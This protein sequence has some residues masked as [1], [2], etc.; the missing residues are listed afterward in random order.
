MKKLLTILFFVSI[1]NTLY[2]QTIFTNTIYMWGNGTGLKE[3]ASPATPTL[4]YGKLFA[5][6]DGH[7][8]WI[9]DAA[10]EFDLTSGSGG[11]TITTFGNGLSFSLGTLSLVTQ[12][13][14]TTDASGLKLVGDV[15]S[16]GNNKF[17][18]TNSVGTRTWAGIKKADLDDL[19]PNEILFGDPASSGQV[20]QND[21]ITVDDAND[22]LGVGVAVPLAT[23]HS[24]ASANNTGTAFPFYIETS[25]GNNVLT[26]ND[27]GV[28]QFSSENF[29]QG[30][31]LKLYG[32]ALGGS[33]FEGFIIHEGTNT[34]FRFG[35]LNDAT[36]VL[37]DFVIEAVGPS[38]SEGGGI[39][40]GYA[41]G[42][43][44][45]KQQIFE[46][47][48]VAAVDGQL[49]IGNTST[50]AWDAATLTAGANITIT[51]SGGGI[52]IASSAGGGTPALTATELGF[53]DGSNLMTSSPLLTYLSTLNAERF[54]STV[55]VMN[56]FGTANYPSG[57]FQI[58]DVNGL[59]FIGDHQGDV[60][61]TY[62]ILADP[63]ETITIDAD[64]GVILPPFA[65]GGTRMVT[66]DNS[67]ILG[68]T[69]IPTS[70]TDEL[71][72]DAVGGILVSP[73]I[74]TDG[75]PSITLA[76]LSGLGTANQILGM[77]AAGTAYEYKS[78]AFGA[79]GTAPN[80]VHTANTMTLNFPLAASGV[81]SG[82][83]SASPQS[84]AGVKTF[85]SGVIINVA[86]T[87]V[88]NVGTTVGTFRTTNAG[89][90][91]A[92]QSMFDVDAS[93]SAA[94][95]QGF[96]FEDVN[97]F[98]L[99]AA[100]GTR[101]IMR[102]F[103][104]IAS[105][106]NTAGSEDADLIF[107]TQAAGAVAAERFRITNLGGFVV[108]STNTTAG[109]TGDQTINK[110][111]GTVNIATGNSSITVTN[112]L[113]TANSLVFAVVR[114]NDAAAI[115]KNVVPGAGSFVITL[116]AATGAE[117]SIGFFVIN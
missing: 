103:I 68:V 26:V 20:K 76:G 55:S 74:Y 117:T 66:A 58:D 71:A 90:N 112:S 69:A 49:L 95:A 11:S 15:T 14:I 28:F 37:D 102:A 10:V 100:N 7:V 89:G 23:I 111:S 48:G 19:D 29:T 56:V 105:L 85:T 98:I 77:D 8:Y 114:T 53:G 109:T 79:T 64:N 106:D 72:Q 35:R 101:R 96:G 2:S 61:A 47:D 25:T 82:T 115:I 31:T 93:N 43:I 12:M 27:A 97:G 113:V 51:N 70:F 40:I 54:E 52:S 30:A 45:F 108:N 81:T 32:P 94:G 78:F 6:T 13:S 83:I 65:G 99:T 16:P 34:L 84:I 46:Y 60:N 75:T 9:N 3:M 22:R 1:L 39:H 44:K 104:N 62:I 87:N 33:L 92:T 42:E 24:K 107:G 17:Y 36:L 4:N 67:G 41:A 86:G 5:K 80:I 91:T 88:F 57:L 59:I 63:A 21:N 73:L 18:K 50:G 38:A 116:N 110:P